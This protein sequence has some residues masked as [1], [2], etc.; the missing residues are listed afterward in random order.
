MG[1]LHG[2]WYDKMKKLLYYTDG[3]NSMIF[4]HIGTKL[5]LEKLKIL[6]YADENFHVGSQI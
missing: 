4:M 5:A 1:S 6:L 2:G 3:W